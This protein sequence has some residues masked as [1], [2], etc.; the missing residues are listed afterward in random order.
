MDNNKNNPNAYLKTKVLTASPEELQLMLF[1]GAIRFCEQ[2]RPAL[3]QKKIEDSYNS[4]TRA[5]K[6]VMEMVNALRDEA[7]PD[8]CA[9]MRALY[10]FCYQRLIDANI[11]KEITPLDEALQILH[12]MRET[13]LLLMEKLKDTKI[14][15]SSEA[16]SEN[17]PSQAPSELGPL[18]VGATVNFQG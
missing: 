14:E 9:N 3:Q 10:L 18:E 13:W 7:D 11:E 2:A 17:Q 8:T 6:I 15:Q 12:H 16:Q 5:Q 4:I 1:D